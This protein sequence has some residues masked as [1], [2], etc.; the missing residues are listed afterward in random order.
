MSGKLRICDGHVD[1]LYALMHQAPGQDFLSLEHGPVTQTSLEQGKVRIF[2]SAFYC[3]DAVNGP[4]TALP[5]LHTL[6]AYWRDHVRMPGPIRNAN[7]IE[8]AWTGTGPAHALLLLENADCLLDMD[9]LEFQDL[10]FRM[11]GLTHIGQNRVG[12][13]NA[14][15]APAG[16]TGPGRRLVRELDRM[17]LTI[18][19]AHLSEPAFREVAGLTSGPL[20]TTHTGL[21]RFCDR[22]RNLSLEQIEVI[23]ERS[24]VIG[25]ALAPEML[26]LDATVTV[27][28]VFVQ[29]DWLA[30]RFGP[31][32]VGLGSDVGGFEG[33]VVGLADH[34]GLPWLAERMD[35]AG[36]RPE[37][38]AAIMG[39]NWYRL[40]STTL[41]RFDA[42]A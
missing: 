30:Q 36:Y 17:G 39:E 35:R 21:R 27:E 37:E 6:L 16:L 32:I 3:P 20:V 13:G 23:A 4:E 28:D 31:S 8:E 2:V 26:A 1:L 42:T 18:D 25:L 7:Q 14:V 22:P 33:A 15:S 11:V 34:A 38:V 40:F 19:M 10:G 29:L 9:L 12:D 24:G 41:S 5:Y